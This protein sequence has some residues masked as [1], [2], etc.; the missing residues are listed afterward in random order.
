MS[1]KPT[2]TIN[3]AATNAT[4]IWA[5]VDAKAPGTPLPLAVAVLVVPPRVRPLLIVSEL[6]EFV[7]PPPRIRPLFRTL[8]SL[9]PAAYA[10]SESV[11][12]LGASPSAST[13]GF[14]N[15]S[16]GVPVAVA[17]FLC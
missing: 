13:T 14:P 11:G 9:S 5:P 3:D 16:T 12:R 15:G 7:N 1:M 4:E 10:V 2:S 6:F 8:A 17:T